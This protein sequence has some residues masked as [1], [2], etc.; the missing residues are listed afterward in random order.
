LRERTTVFAEM[1]QAWAQRLRDL[2][3]GACHEVK[4]SGGPLTEERIA[5]YRSAYAVILAVGTP[6]TRA[7]RRPASAAKPNR[8]RHPISSTAC[9]PTP[10][11]SGDS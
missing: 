6:T 10:T 2:R 1:R 3:V 8:A 5:H 11:M 4:A 9:A 7:R